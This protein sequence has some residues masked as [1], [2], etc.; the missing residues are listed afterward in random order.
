MLNKFHRVILTFFDI[1]FNCLFPLYH[2]IT[3]SGLD[4]EL[5]HSTSIFLSADTNFSLISICTATGFTENSELIFKKM[6]VI[7]KKQ[8]CSIVKQNICFYSK[9]LCNTIIN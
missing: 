7:E 3:A 6:K 8:K 4:P 1:L 2:V 9:N 5:L